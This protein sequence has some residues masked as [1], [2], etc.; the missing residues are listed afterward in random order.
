MYGSPEVTTGGNALQ[1]YASIRLE[2][3]RSTTEKNS[4]MN[5]DIKE[6]NQTTVK[7]IKN[8]C[9]PPFRSATFNIM[10]GTGIDR[11]SEVVD[12]GVELGIIEKAGTWYSYQ[13][14]KLGQG[15]EAVKEVLTDNEEMRDEI[16]EK[17]KNS[18]KL[19]PN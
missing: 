5:G 4:V 14:S 12:L 9:A 19:K 13:E 3:R 17:I 16:E 2:V 10:Y 1:F 11:I 18:I 15:K 6:G 8:K 7:V